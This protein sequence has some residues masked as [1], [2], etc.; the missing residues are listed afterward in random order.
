MTTQRGHRSTA[1]DL[2]QSTNYDDAWIETLRTMS[3]KT[4]EFSE[5]WKQNSYISI[6]SVDILACSNLR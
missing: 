3:Q 1:R 2:H 6:V 5:D 4:F